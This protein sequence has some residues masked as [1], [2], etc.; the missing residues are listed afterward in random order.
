MAEHMS[1]TPQEQKQLAREILESTLIGARTE[2]DAMLEEHLKD[3]PAEWRVGDYIDGVTI[4]YYFHDEY[5][6]EAKEL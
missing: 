6:E 5:P 4:L 3:S 2:Q 1:R